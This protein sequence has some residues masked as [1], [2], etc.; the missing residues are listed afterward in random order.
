MTFQ[1]CPGIAAVT[2]TF[3]TPDGQN[4]VN[5]WYV[6]DSDGSEWSNS[7]LTLLAVAFKDWFETGDG[8]GNTYR[9]RVSDQCTLDTINVRDLT[10]EVGAEAALAVGDAGE[11]T[12]QMLNNGLTIAMS[13]RSGV[14]G[15]S[16]RGRKFW[17]GLCVNSVDLPDANTVN[18]DFVSL[19]IPAFDSLIASVTAYGGDALATL[20]ILSR[21]NKDAVPIA[22]HKRDNGIG[23]DVVGYTLVDTNLD[24]QRRRAPGHNRHH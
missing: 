4:A 19:A 8:S 7:D 16:F 24:F 1:P 17:V 18:S 14:A 21:Y 3:S 6:S 15:R 12:T 11:D 9:A 22:P 10:I 20:V 2:F 5:T 23:T 13:E